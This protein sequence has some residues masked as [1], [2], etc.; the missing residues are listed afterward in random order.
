MGEGETLYQ[1][2]EYGYDGHACPL[3]AGPQG[4]D[5]AGVWQAFRE[6][7][8][9]ERRR[10]TA[11]FDWEHKNAYWA[12]GCERSKASFACLR[13]HLRAAF[14]DMAEGADPCD[15]VGVFVDTLRGHGLRRVTPVVVNVD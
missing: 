3:L 2:V 7:Y 13:E 11:A 15:E 6:R 4:V 1:L 14:P 9:G 10:L 8:R 12:D 5:V